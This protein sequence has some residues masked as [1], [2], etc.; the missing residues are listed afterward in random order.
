M[1]LLASIRPAV[2]QVQGYIRSLC[3]FTIP[4]LRSN[5]A[6]FDLSLRVEMISG[7]AQSP[8]RT[9]DAILHGA[10]WNPRRY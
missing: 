6:S 8:R 3:S 9:A 1:P 4:P 7:F 2:R 10:G 5:P